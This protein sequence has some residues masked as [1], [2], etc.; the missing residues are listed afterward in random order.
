MED[1]M[2]KMAPNVALLLV[3][4]AVSP[5]MAQNVSVD[6]NGFGGLYVPTTEF[7]FASEFLPP[8]VSEATAKHKSA[9]IFGGRLGLWFSPAFGIE[10]EF[11]YA[12]SDAE[13]KFDG[14]DICGQEI[15]GELFECDA[16]SWQGALKGLYR[17]KPQPDAIWS[18]HLGAGAGVVGRGGK[19]YDEAEGTTD[20]AGV[21][22][23]GASFDVSPQIAIRLDAE[24][25]FYSLQI[26]DADTG[27]ALGDS[28]FTT[29]LTFT[30]GVTVKLKS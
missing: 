10:G 1:D 29:D 27:D 17:I 3:L 12:L 7:Q 2:I 4:A 6:L 23:V 21:A 15:D 16:N 25:Y 24:G 20:I 19:A 13:V 30:G 5:T 14:Q 18:L 26:K 11:G 22:D 8:G 28:K 9:V